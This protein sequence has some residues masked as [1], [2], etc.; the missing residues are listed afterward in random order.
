MIH[1]SPL[2]A[3]ASPA[4]LVRPLATTDCVKPCGRSTSVAT[5][6]PAIA[7]WPDQPLTEA[8]SFNVVPAAA[9]TGPA[10]VTVHDWPLPSVGVVHVTW[11]PCWLQVPRLFV[12][13]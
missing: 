4:G 12:I 9:V 1:R 13:V 10:M 5:D 8:E 7:V 3:N 11:A 2:G 6:E